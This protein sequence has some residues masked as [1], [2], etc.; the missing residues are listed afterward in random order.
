MHIIQ[1]LLPPQCDQP[2]YDVDG[3]TVTRVLRVLLDTKRDGQF[4]Q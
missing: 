2:T 3:T 1:K 4:A